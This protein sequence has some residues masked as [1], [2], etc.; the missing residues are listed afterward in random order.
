MY[1]LCPFSLGIPTLI[2]AAASVD[3]VTAVSLF[4]IFLGLVFS[5]GTYSILR[6]NMYVRKVLSRMMYIIAHIM[7]HY[8]YRVFTFFNIQG[9]P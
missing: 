3:V 8:S 5:D 6:V 4:G 9:S 7:F 2:V 1:V